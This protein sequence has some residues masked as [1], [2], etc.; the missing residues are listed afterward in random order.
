MKAPL[1]LVVGFLGAGKTTFIRELLPELERRGLEPSVVINDYV[2]AGVDASSLQ[3]NDRIVKAISGSCI[4]CDS[5]LDLMAA[6]LQMPENPRRVVLVEANGTSDPT[7]LIEYLMLSPK[8]R[9]RY[10]PVLQV[11]VVDLEQWQARQGHNELERLQIQTASHITFSRWEGQGD[12]RFAEVR[13]DLLSINPQAKW[14]K[15]PILAGELEAL[16]ESAPSV[17]AQNCRNA[18]AEDVRNG[19]QTNKGSHNHDHDEHEHHDHEHHHH[20]H[21]DQH[22][23]AHA[24]VGLNLSLPEVVS[25]TDVEDWLKSLPRDVLRAKG[26]ARTE[27]NPEKWVQFQFVQKSELRSE[28]TLTSISYQPLAPPCAVLIGVRLDRESLEKNLATHVSM[29]VPHASA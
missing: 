13:D 28:V 10:D 27:T 20:D 23:L 17:E 14:V 6:L 24:F 5:M 12:E 16:V 2:N 26:V 3:Q 22:K 1:V 8:L 19:E 29:E 7:T 25:P 4:C 9:K 21:H 18:A 15:F 11:A